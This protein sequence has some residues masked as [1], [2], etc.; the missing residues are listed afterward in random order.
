MATEEHKPD[1]TG[2]P[3]PK[4]SSKWY[5][6]LG[7]W[8]AIAFGV[9]FTGGAALRALSGLK[10]S[11]APEFGA[12]TFWFPLF[13]FSLGGGIAIG[14]LILTWWLVAK[15]GVTWALGALILAVVLFALFVWPSAYR[16]EKD[17]RREATCRVLQVQRWTGEAKCVLPP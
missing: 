2:K 6:I 3:T 15:S 9:L 16:Y 5:R 17:R 12:S 14:L 1:S 4:P 8:S 10:D 13:I 11:K 7:T